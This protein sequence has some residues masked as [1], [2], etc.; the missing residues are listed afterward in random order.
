MGATQIVG[1]HGESRSG[2][3]GQDRFQ[4]VFGIDLFDTRCERRILADA[5]QETECFSHPGTAG[6]ITRHASNRSVLAGMRWQ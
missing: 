3:E 5:P 1:R 2:G 6:S 4:A